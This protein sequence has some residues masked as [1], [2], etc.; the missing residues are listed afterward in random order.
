LVD[1]IEIVTMLVVLLAA[2]AAAAAAALVVS[3][4]GDNKLRTGT[5]FDLVDDSEY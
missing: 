2:V 5:F 3:V 1:V 4:C